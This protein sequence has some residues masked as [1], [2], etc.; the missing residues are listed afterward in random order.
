MTSG[1]RERWVRGFVI[2]VCSARVTPAVMFEPGSSIAL[3]KRANF[4][5]GKLSVVLSF[6]DDS[7]AQRYVWTARLVL[8]ELVGKT[9]FLACRAR[10]SLGYATAP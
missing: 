9:A 7:R 2:F 6:R 3:A 8:L 10:Y 5:N 1:R 4:S